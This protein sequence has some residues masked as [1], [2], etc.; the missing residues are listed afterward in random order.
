MLT[1]ELSKSTSKTQPTV[2]SYKD[3]LENSINYFNGD[4]L[5]ASTWMNKYAMKDKSGKFLEKSPD[6]MHR[7]MAKE[8]ARIESLYLH[9]THLN[10]SFKHLSAYGQSREVL[11]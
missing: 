1:A 3:V 9:K 8:F 10:G 2:Y 7:R 4:E 6:D 11:T 5:A